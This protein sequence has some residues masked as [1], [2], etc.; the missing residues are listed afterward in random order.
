MGVKDGCT[1]RDDVRGGELDDAIFAASFGKLIKGEAPPIYGDPKRFFANTH[2]TTALAK[3]CR[4]VFGRLA[5]TTESGTIIRLS[6]GFGGGKTHALMALWH[7]AKASGDPALGADLLPPAGRPS[8]VT[9]AG[10]DAEGAGYPVFARRGDMEARSLAAALAYELGGPSA[11]NALGTA[12]A[13]AAS[14]DDAAVKAMLPPGPVLILLDEL[15]LYMAKLTEQERGNLIGFLRTLMTE[16]TNRRQAVLVLTDPKDQVADSPNAARL[17]ILAKTFEEQTGRQATV[18]EPI[19]EESAQV[20]IRRLFERVDAGAAAKASADHHALYKRVADA[21]PAS[22]PER[23]ITTKYAET[24]RACYPLHPRLLQ[25][26]EDRLR[27]MPEYNLSRGTLRLFARVVRNVWD[28]PIRNPDLITA[29]EVDW[30]DPPIQTDLL[31][32]LD[33][34]RF[35]AAVGAD[36]EGHGAELDGEDPSRV[37]VRVA[38]AILLESLTL[39][40]N[41]GLDGAELALAVL[42]PEDAGPE[43]AEAMERLGGACWHLYP[44]GGSLDGWRFRYEPNILKQIEERTVQIPRADA[45]DRLRSD[46]QKAYAGSFAKLVSWP[47]GTREVPERSDLQLALCDSEE[48]AKAVTAWRDDTAG[49]A[50]ARANRNAIV[51]VAPDA[52][53]LEKAVGRVARLLAA[54]AIERDVPATE[55]GKLAREQIKKLMPEL[56]KVARLE[57]ARAFNRLALADG[58]I[59][60][61]DERFITPPDTGPMQLPSGQDAVKAFLEDRKLIWGSG[62][63]LDGQFFIERVFKGAPPMADEPG[64]R[65]T[66]ALHRRFLNAAGLR[67][68]ADP[69]ALRNSVL[70]GVSEGRLVVRDAGG[71]AF[72]SIGATYR[73]NNETR[74]DEGRK[75]TTLAISEEVLVALVGTEPATGWLKLDGLAEAPPKPG[76]LPIPP[77]PPAGVG[78]TTATDLGLAAEYADTRPLLTLRITCQSA[79]DALRALSLGQGLGAPTVTVDAD[80]V[81]VMK[82]GGRLNLQLTDGKVGAAV[83][84]LQ[85]AQ[86]LGNT[87]GMD[88]TVRVGVTFAFGAAGKPD[89]GALLRTMGLGLP[90]GA[91]VEAKLAPLST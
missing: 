38:S 46:V 75:L 86:T 67:L 10:I 90:E 81:G 1:P 82:D 12:N 50:V 88:A 26:A 49:A 73:Q 79:A 84:P 14:P 31:E 11:L 71:V 21:S 30:S 24:I 57:A 52:S 42:R 32:R 45:L 80:L 16:V 13:A 4:D 40:E 60:T 89:L 54:E 63:S 7:L 56:R 64:A 43:P 78:P 76:E 36:I 19:G 44:T 28:N 70:R 48:I 61:I 3:L 53:S 68:A 20:I 62:D 2:P 27:T 59:L 29:G 9:V 83:K 69:S 35:R 39:E 8:G 91:T 47:K 18:I 22:I 72:D 51:A 41:A 6:T 5:S 33:R 34:E 65:T 17:S 58:A 74:R 85:L 15:V 55:G 25:T 87:L 77:P 37:H 66:G 23:A